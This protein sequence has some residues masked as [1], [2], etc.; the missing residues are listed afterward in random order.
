MHITAC[1]CTKILKDHMYEGARALDVGSGSG[2][3]TACMGYMVSVS[4]SVCVHM[5]IYLPT[6]MCVFVC[7]MSVYCMNRELYFMV[8]SFYQKITKFS[9]VS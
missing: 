4:E 3:L 9:Y 7:L 1:P 6:C 5:S 2:Y 8:D